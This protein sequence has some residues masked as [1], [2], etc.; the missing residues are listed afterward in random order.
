MTGE[1]RMEDYNYDYQRVIDAE[2]AE[3][4]VKAAPPVSPEPKKPY[5][6]MIAAVIVHT[7]AVSLVS[8]LFGAVTFAVTGK[9]IDA[10]S[11][12]IQVG[13]AVLG[14][15]YW[16]LYILIPFLFAKSTYK[17][18]KPRLAFV[19]CFY[20]QVTLTSAVESVA[21]KIVEAAE[22]NL[23]VPNLGTET[24]VLNVVSSGLSTVVT[25][26]IQLVILFQ[27]VKWAAEN[28]LFEEKPS[29]REMLL[30]KEKP[31]LPVIAA[32]C[33]AFMC[34][35]DSGLGMLVMRFYTEEAGARN[36]MLLTLSCLVIF[37]SV[38]LCFA[39]GKRTCSRPDG[40]LLFTGLVT[41][42]SA[43]SFGQWAVGLIYAVVKALRGSSVPA[44][45]DTV[46][47]VV[48]VA[49]GAVTAAWI[50]H[51]VFHRLEDRSEA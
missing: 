3:K 47:S 16:A 21:T 30:M 18:L 1:K 11:P 5:G 4:T 26:I 46:V 48:S 34:L 7:V 49:A 42:A 31:K 8:V 23:A 19:G 44:S 20:V 22:N 41:G 17:T 28:G 10:S 15:L 51:F 50:A 39:V 9:E 33:A 35:F 37:G 36:V 24:A 27:V 25:I 2:K 14:A 6:K 29:V 38:V 43:V 12:F 40:A 13:L 32:A 45:V